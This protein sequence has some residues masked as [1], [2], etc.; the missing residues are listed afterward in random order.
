MPTEPNLSQRVRLAG[1]QPIGDLMQQALARPELISLAAGFVDQQTLPVDLTRAALDALLANG[2]AARAALQYGATAGHPPLREA[3]LARLIEA[4]RA[5]TPS[6]VHATPPTVEQAMVTAGSNQFLQLIS[7]ILVDPGD[8]VLTTAPTYFVYLG[9]LK[10]LGARAIGVDS[11]DR[12]MIPE[13]LDE[14]FRRLH[15]AG[16]L[17]RVRALYLVDYFDNPR[18]VSLAADRRPAVLE[19]V[20]RWSARQRIFILEDAAYRE[21]RYDGADLPSLRSYD[22]E[23]DTVIVAD[24]FSKSYS[25]GIRVGW[26]ILPLDLVRPFTDLKDNVDFGAPNFVQHLMATM[27]RQGGLP[28]HVQKLRDRYRRK[29]DVALTALAQRCRGLPG[30]SWETPAGGLY[31]WL[32]TPPRVSAGPG[33]KL[34]DAALRHN[35]LYVPGE[36]C[37]PARGAAVQKNTLRLCFGVLPE[38]RLAAGVAALGDA[39]ESCLEQAC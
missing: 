4:D 20:R 24:T 11:D 26:G 32:T 35:V 5:A 15:A 18:G 10:N 31:V 7:E 8:I 13:A 14:Q 36:Y 25:P 16:E 38:D 3:V 2:A 29:R 12:G 23:G 28:A 22:D 33:G 9:L 34:I 27:L 37:F 1:G 17:G 19:I 30:V 39:I 21:L 6:R